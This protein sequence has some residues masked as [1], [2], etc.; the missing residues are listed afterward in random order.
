M[1]FLLLMFTSFARARF[2]LNSLIGL[3]L[4]GNVAAAMTAPVTLSTTALK[5]TLF[6]LKGTGGDR[7]HGWRGGL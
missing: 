4:L 6:T 7:S 3:L 1:G 5:V 2:L